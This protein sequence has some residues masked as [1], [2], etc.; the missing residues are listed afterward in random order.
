MNTYAVEITESI[1]GAGWS[2][3]MDNVFEAQ[4][5]YAI[6]QVDYQNQRIESILDDAES[7]IR[8]IRKNLSSSPQAPTFGLHMARDLDEAVTTRNL[9]VQ[10]IRTLSNAVKKVTS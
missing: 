5:Q 4:I 7:D 3:N 9:N 2:P 6:D 8:R 10:I 1:L